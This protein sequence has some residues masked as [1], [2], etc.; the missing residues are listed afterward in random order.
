MHLLTAALLLGY[1]YAPTGGELEAPIRYVVFPLL[2][3]SGMAMWQAPR[4]RRALK[5]A[6]RR[7]P[8]LPLAHLRV[9]A[10][11]APVLA[12]TRPRLERRR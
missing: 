1:V 6:R 8:D 3:V 12:E 2:A 7:R 9:L 4:L 5:A 10:E 11:H